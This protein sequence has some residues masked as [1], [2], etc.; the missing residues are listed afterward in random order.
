MEQAQPER[1]SE[2]RYA[3]DAEAT[4]VMV[5]H[6]RSWRGR[7][8]ELSPEGCRLRANKFC[9]MAAPEGIPIA[10]YDF[11]TAHKALKTQA[12]KLTAIV[13]ATG[14]RTRNPAM[15][16][17]KRLIIGHQ[18]RITRVRPHSAVLSNPL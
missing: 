4:V 17:R 3:V 13:T 16:V 5:N 14:S 12:P 2:Q 9:A 11:S 10:I 7:L 6:G 1:R 15:K 8:I 18:R